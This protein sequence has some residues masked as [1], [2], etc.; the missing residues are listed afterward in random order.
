MIHRAVLDHSVGKDLPVVAVE[1]FESL[2]G[3]GV[4]AT[5]SGIKVCVN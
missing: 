3:R 4:V 2:P 1:S 5:L